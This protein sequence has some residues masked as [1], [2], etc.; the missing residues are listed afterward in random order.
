MMRQRASL[1]L[2]ALVAGSCAAFFVWQP[3]LGSLYDDSV[4]YLLMAQWFAGTPLAAV[5]EAARIEKYPPLFPLVLALSGGA[6]DWRIAHAVVALSFALSVYALGAHAFNITSSLRIAIAAAIVYAVMPGTWLNMKGIL[7]EFPYMAASFAAL[8][9][10][11]ARLERPSLRTSTLLGILLAAALLTRTVGIALWGALALSEGVRLL[12][13]GDAQRA[14]STWPAFA[15]PVLLAG[16]WYALRPATG[17]DPYIHYGAR[18]FSE[19][20]PNLQA[21]SDAWLNWILVFWG[22]PWKPTFILAAAVG[23]AG[24]G[25]TLARALHGEFDALYCVLFLAILIAWPFP[26]QMYRLA[27]PI[28]PLLIVNALWTA[29]RFATRM[30]E[31]GRGWGALAALVPLTACL[32]AVLWLVIERSQASETAGPNR[33]LSDIAEFYRI[34]DRRAAVANAARQVGAF[35]DLERIRGSTP[36]DA[37]VLSIM[38]GYMALIARRRAIMLERSTDGRALARQATAADYIYLSNAHPRDSALRD[39]NPLELWSTV[40][41]FTQPVWVRSVPGGDPQAVLLRVEHDKIQAGAKK[42]DP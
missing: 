23:I 28:A 32:P 12:R 25:G 42:A 1:A 18:A 40:T 36:E 2:V 7:S 20:V 4:S 9:W 8:A 13:T 33:K 26:G 15:I 6:D 3:V 39:G 17:E 24:L 34:P 35:S 27:F 16:L 29:E 21:L 41:P 30:G 10:H 38:P 37:R 5:T 11:G 22:E 31:R 14:R 19:V